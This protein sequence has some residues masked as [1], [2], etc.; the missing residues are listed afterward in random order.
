[1]VIA[2]SSPLMVGVYQ[3]ST[4]IESFESVEKT[5]D[6]LP[7]LLEKILHR[8]KIDTIYYARGPG[9]FMAIKV[10][11]IFLKSISIV[12]GIDLLG[13]DG[14][15]FNKFMP[16]KAHGS[17]YFMKENGK[18]STIKLDKPEKEYKFKLPKL[19]DRSIFSKENE[20]LYILPAI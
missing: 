3:D 6:A 9:S 1:M 10:A 17:F 20:P 8:Y 4:L 2:L 13:T 18:I 7:V 16:I 19:L 15:N 14:F 12:K 11:Y 5:S